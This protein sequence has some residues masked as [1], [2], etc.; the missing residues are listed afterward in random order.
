M[1]ESLNCILV[2]GDNVEDF[3]Q[4]TEALEKANITARVARVSSS[5]ELFVYFE[6]SS[7]KE[8]AQ[9]WCFPE[10]LF[11]NLKLADGNPLPKL[12]SLKDQTAN[13]FTTIVISG[14]SEVKQIRD[15][16]QAGADTILIKPVNSEELVSFLTFKGFAVEKE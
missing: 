10:L 15:A 4:I 14:S 1:P 13:K 2:A 6:K 8:N 7:K 11:L 9:Q 12:R 5:A 3:A 16:Y